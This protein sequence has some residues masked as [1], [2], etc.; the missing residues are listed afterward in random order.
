MTSIVITPW[1]ICRRPPLILLDLQGNRC[2]HTVARRNRLAITHTVARQN[3]PT[4][5]HT[6]E[7]KLTG[8]G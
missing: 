6:V 2:R 1:R 3:R 8:K 4:M 7:G 5:T